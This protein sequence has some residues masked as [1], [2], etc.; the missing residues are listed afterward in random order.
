MWADERSTI[1]HWMKRE[2]SVTRIHAGE[3]NGDVILEHTQPE[4]PPG[5]LSVNATGA[6]ALR[7]PELRLPPSV[8]AFGKRPVD[9]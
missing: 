6:P 8:L 3:P 2:N 4:P 1:S 5:C 7:D 9:Q